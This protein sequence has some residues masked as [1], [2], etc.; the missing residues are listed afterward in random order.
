MLYK[1]TGKELK[2]EYINNEKKYEVR[3]IV[4]ADN[5]I[6]WF[7]RDIC[8]IIDNFEDIR[9]ENVSVEVDTLYMF[10]GT[11]GGYDLVDAYTLSKM[12][13]SLNNLIINKRTEDNFSKWILYDKW[14]IDF[15]NLVNWLVNKATYTIFTQG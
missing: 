1:I 7:L 3:V 14:E 8:E 11:N 12:I 10:E 4:D 5:N 15:K 2:L 9:K 13:I 6:W